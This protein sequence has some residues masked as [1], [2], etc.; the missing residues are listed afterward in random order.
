MR[1]G[2]PIFGSRIAPRCTVA[3]GMLI[4][5]FHGNRATEKENVAFEQGNWQEILSVI[6]RYRVDTIVCGGIARSEKELLAGQAVAVVEN[7]A[8]T[9]DEVVAAIIAGCLRSGP[10]NFCP[11][12]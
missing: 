3:D 11:V 12:F 4:V 2:V 6:R 10:P 9:I 7:V 5:T 1:Y 8:C